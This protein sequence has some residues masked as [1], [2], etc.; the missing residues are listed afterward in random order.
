MREP[1]AAWLDSA[2]WWADK[3]GAADRYALATALTINGKAA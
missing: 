3:R 2:A 1:L